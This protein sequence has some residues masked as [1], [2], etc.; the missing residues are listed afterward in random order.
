VRPAPQSPTGPQRAVRAR[1]RATVALA[2]LLAVLAGAG[3]LAPGAHGHFSPAGATDPDL[4][5]TLTG[6]SP[7]PGTDPGA[8]ADP[9]LD[10]AILSAQLTL[11][12]RHADARVE[13][14]GAALGAAG[15]AAS[16]AASTSEEDGAALAAA[17]AAVVAARRTLGADERQVAADAAGVEAHRAALGAD[18][19]QLSTLAVDAYVGD[20]APPTSVPGSSDGLGPGS[21]PAAVSGSGGAGPGPDAAALDLQ[22]VQQTLAEEAEVGAVVRLVESS[23]SAAAAD[24]GDSSAAERT[25]AGEAAAARSSLG[26]DLGVA[27]QRQQAA[28]A[29]ASAAAAATHSLGAARAALTRAVVARS[30]LIA[31]FRGPAETGDAPPPSILGP[32]ALDPAELVAWFQQ[33]GYVDLTSTPVVVLARWY[34][35]VGRAED[36]RGDLAF[37]QAVLETG[38]FSST[39]AVADNNYAGIGYCDSCSGGLHF[40]SPHAGVVGQ[41]QLL[42]TYADPGLTANQ[43][44]SP[45]ALPALDPAAQYRRGCCPTWGSLTGTWASDPEYGAKILQL[46]ATMLASALARS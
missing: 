14:A 16:L 33:S 4:V 6:A 45:P 32:P 1:T 24:L 40:P 18:L 37:A 38:G 13:A 21:A 15:L 22:A 11:V 9:A 26:F 20:L 35:D 39:A 31:S 8:V 46:Y 29:A 41:I 12:T 42:R 23:A 30:A 44:A 28:G 27:R 10:R 43:L 19:T 2:C 25:A 3:P 17:R 36:V 7:A 34:I 5:A